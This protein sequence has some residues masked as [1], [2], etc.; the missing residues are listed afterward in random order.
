MTWLSDFLDHNG[1]HVDVG[2]GRC[3]GLVC[4]GVGVRTFSISRGRRDM[5]MES[6]I[7]GGG[8]TYHLSHIE[9][10]GGEAA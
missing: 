5:V 6:V 7:W 9:E 4:C 10:D 2:D 8:V 1:S 3:A